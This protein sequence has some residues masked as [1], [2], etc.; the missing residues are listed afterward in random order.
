MDEL[1]SDPDNAQIRPHADELRLGGGAVIGLLLLVNV[2]FGG[3][4][5]WHGQ[6]YPGI[7][8]ALAPSLC[9]LAAAGL[10]GSVLV[11]SRRQIVGGLVA[12]AVVAGIGFA[13]ALHS[14]FAIVFFGTRVPG[15]YWCAACLALGWL[16][17]NRKMATTG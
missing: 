9:L 17:T 7:A 5:A 4:A 2:V 11:G 10:K 13:L 8:G 3:L 1:A 14:G 15:A 6:V 16:G 12:A